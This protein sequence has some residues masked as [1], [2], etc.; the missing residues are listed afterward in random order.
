MRKSTF[1]IE[2]S[3]EIEKVY[4]KR[5]QFASAMRRYR[6]S[7]LAV[8]GLIMVIILVLI[9]VF[10]DFL[11]DYENDAI[12][13]NMSIRLEEPNAEHI[14]GTDQYGRDVFAR[15]V[16]GARISLL[17]GI[18]SNIFAVIVGLIIGSIAGYFGGKLDN[19]LMRLMDI[20][21]ALPFSIL[22]IAIVAGLGTGLDKTIIALGI[23]SVAPFV[24]LIRASILS[25][26]DQEY[27]E[28]AKSCGTSN[29]RIIYKHIIPNVMGP[30][31]VQLTQN[32]GRNIISLAALSFIGLGVQAPM[33][34]WGTMLS[35]GKQ[36]LRFSPYLVTIPGIA[37]VITVMAFNLVGDGLRDAFDP[38]LK[39]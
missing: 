17:G 24:R 34:E 32:V 25:I 10:A 31:I 8:L 28:A 19:I 6:K 39:N 29:F 16:H 30:L 37:I 2:S 23:A 18:G 33:P 22:A 13:Q 27:I 5:S 21:M 1:P 12:R 35:E 36:V 38:R 9:A 3:G 26:K 15:I 20:L 14:F 7:K 11:A 4:K